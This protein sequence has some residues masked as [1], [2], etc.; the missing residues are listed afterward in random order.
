MSKEKRNIYSYS[1][2]ETAHNAG[3][4]YAESKRESLS[5]IIER[6]LLKLKDKS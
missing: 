6:F 5:R 1:A 4:E 3:K 2:L